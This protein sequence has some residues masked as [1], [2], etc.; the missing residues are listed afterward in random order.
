MEALAVWPWAK[1]EP[2]RQMKLASWLEIDWVRLRRG[3][4]PPATDMPRA[5]L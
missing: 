5:K 2:S 4:I 3:A 1:L